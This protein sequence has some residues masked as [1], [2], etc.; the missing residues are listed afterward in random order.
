MTGGA[1]HIKILR[2]SGSLKALFP[3]P[4]GAALEAV[5]LNTAGG[6]TGSD[7]MQIEA[8]A[9]AGA[10]LTLSSQAVERA[11]R[12]V[13]QS[14]AKVTLKLK[15]GPLARIDWLPQETA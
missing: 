14:R 8:E 4:V 13:G 6:L 7:K 12:A 1:S 5:F 15:V 10:H 2:Q 9:G 3:R 11:D